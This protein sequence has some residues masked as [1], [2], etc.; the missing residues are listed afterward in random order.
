[1]IN[2]VISSKYEH[3]TG[4]YEGKSPNPSKFPLS[5]KIKQRVLTYF[6][7]ES[8]A[9]EIFERANTLCLLHEKQLYEL[10]PQKKIN[11]FTYAKVNIRFITNKESN[12][13]EKIEIGIKKIPGHIEAKPKLQELR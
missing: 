3:F 1:M 10:T 7:K 5:D 2:P 8:F 9:L 6:P 11:E 13:V 12:V 4:R